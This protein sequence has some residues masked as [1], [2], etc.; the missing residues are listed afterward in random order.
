MMAA[1]GFL[2]VAA[3]PVPSAVPWDP[4]PAKVVTT[5]SGSWSAAE[6]LIL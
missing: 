1:L 5:G 4:E 6:R 3:V 2:N